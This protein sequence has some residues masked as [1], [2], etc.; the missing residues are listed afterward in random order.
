[1]TW[2]YGM[3]RQWFDNPF[4]WLGCQ[5]DRNENSFRHCINFQ[6]STDV[7]YH[8]TRH[9]DERHGFSLYIYDSMKIETI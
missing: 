6:S 9:D 4:K 5:H 1:M 8:Q 7:G 2:T 3:D